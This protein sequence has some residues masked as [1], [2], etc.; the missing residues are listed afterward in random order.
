MEK[1]RP[2]PRFDFSTLEQKIIKKQKLSPEDFTKKKQKQALEAQLK[3]ELYK[4]PLPPVEK[5]YPIYSDTPNAWQADLMFLR[6]VTTQKETYSVAILNVININTKFAFS[7]P[8]ISKRYESKDDIAFKPH[9][10]PKK[11][12]EGNILVKVF[13]KTSKQVL[14]AFQKI[15]AQ[16]QQY[17]DSEMFQQ[18]GVRLQFDTLY[19]DDGSEFKGVFLEHCAKH[20]IHVVVFKPSEGSKR[21]MGVV[22]RFNRTLREYLVYKWTKDQAKKDQQWD[23]KRWRKLPINQAL[24]YVLKRYNFEK[25]HTAIRKFLRWG[26]NLQ[27]RKQQLQKGL[28]ATPYMMSMPKREG[29]MKE[30]KQQLTE[31]TDAFYKPVIEK[32]MSHTNKVRY[33]LKKDLFDKAG[34][35]TWSKPVQVS[36][37]HSFQRGKDKY[38][39]LSFQVEGTNHRILPYDI[40]IR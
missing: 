20:N 15:Q 18:D 35:S 7:V 16:A 29:Q 38:H 4:G 24:P 1:K 2:V 34:G 36:Q 39:G 33:H 37:R 21:R 13:N 19:V 5:W 3:E 14:Q 8:I 32:M 10:N 23:S 9:Y 27:G 31:E 6:Y 28:P 30:Y 12:E 25:T 26:Y 22:E 17:N 40:I 11:N